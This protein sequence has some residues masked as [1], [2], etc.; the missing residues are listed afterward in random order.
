MEI[1]DFII[2]LKGKG[3]KV[4]LK[5]DDLA[6]TLPKQGVDSGLID[7]IKNQKQALVQYL[8]LHQEGVSMEGIPRAP[9]QDSYVLSSAQL[10]LWTLSQVPEES[11]AYNM[12]AVMPIEGEYQIDLL[13]RAIDAVIDRH[14]IL[15]TVFK[16]NG[17]G[18][19]RQQV[20]T[21]DTLGFETKT[22]DLSASDRASEQLESFV[23]ED[24]PQP[25]D[26][27][28]GPL[29]RVCLFVM[30]AKQHVI[31]FNL[32]HIIG[33]GW[34]DQILLGDVLAYYK[35]FEQETAV[36]LPALKIQYKDYAVWEQGKLQRD[37]LDQH[38]AY[39]LEHLAG[40]LPIM[41]LPSSKIR[42]PY[43][44]N[45]GRKLGTYIGQAN[46]KHL[47]QYCHTH[48]G[49]L[50]MGFM[51]VLKVLFSRYTQQSDQIIGST[52]SG[53]VHADLKNQIGFYANKIAFRSQLAE[54]DTFDTFFSKV[55]QL[56]LDAYAHQVYPFDHLI[57]NLKIKRDP[58]RSA[59]VDVVIDYA[60]FGDIPIEQSQRDLGDEVKDQGTVQSKFDLFFRFQETG[61]DIHFTVEY[62]ADVYHHDIVVQFVKHFK[63]L[64]YKI[65]EDTQQNLCDIRFL[66]DDEIHRIKHVFNATAF[67]YPD[68]STLH[69]LFSKQARFSPEAIAI[70]DHANHT[71]Q[72]VEER[73]NQ[74]G[75]L[76]INKLQIAKEARVGLLQNRSALFM[77]SLL[78]VF[79]SGG[80]YVP[81]NSAYPEE[82]LLF[83]LED[84][85]IEVLLVD[86][87]H[88]GLAKRLQSQSTQLKTLVLV[89][90]NLPTAG[91]FQYNK[92]DIDTEPIVLDHVD[93][94][95]DDLAYVIY[96]SGSTGRP[97]GVM[98]AHQGLVNTAYDHIDQLGLTTDD[99]ILQFVSLSFDGSLLDIFMTFFAGATLVLPEDTIVKDPT[100]FEAFIDAEKVTLV[101]L[102]PAYL[103]ALNQPKL[104][105]VHTIIT[106]GE[107]ASVKDA[108]HYA[109]EKRFFN[110]YGP[111]ECTVNSTL[112]EVDPNK[113]YTN[114]P[115]GKPSANKKILI[116]DKN[117]NLEPIGVV[118]EICISG[119]GIAK[120]YQNNPV[121]TKAK[122]VQAPDSMDGVLYKTGDL[123]RWLPHGVIEY[124][125]R[126]DDQVK[127]RGYRIEPGEIESALV[128]HKWVDMAAVSIKPD[129]EGEP[130]L[131]AYIQCWQGQDLSLEEIRSYLSRLL[132]AFML[133]GQYIYV[134]TFPL[135]TNGKVDR[136]RLEEVEGHQVVSGTAA[137]PPAN[138]TEEKLLGIWEKLLGRDKVSTQ[139]NFFDLGGHSIKATKLTFQL[140]STF[141]VNI[142]LR[143]VFTH[144]TIR[145]QAQLVAAKDKDVDVLIPK[146]GPAV[147]YP[148]SH[149]QK[150]LWVL[151]QFEG[152]NVAY[153][154]PAVI[155]LDKEMDI[156]AFKKAVEAT[157]DRH[158]ILR[159]AFRE[160]EAGELR[161]YVIPMKEFD[162]QIDTI[163]VAAKTEEDIF[164]LIDQD[165]TAPFDLVNG[166]LIRVK[167]GFDQK[168]KHIFYYNIHHIIS[169]GWS[170]EVLKKDVLTFYEAFIKGFSPELP[171]LRIQYKDYTAWQ[172]SQ[173]DTGGFQRHRDY[174]LDKL[175]GDLAVLDLPRTKN[176]PSVKTYNGNELSTYL[177]VQVV[178]RAKQYLGQK[179]GTM[180]MLLV[181]SLKALLHRYTHQEDIII[182]S[183]IAGREHPD[184]EHQI[185]FYVNTLALRDEIKAS[186]SFDELFAKV[187][188]TVA[189]AFRHQQ[190]PF[191]LLVDELDLRRDAS[192]SPIFDIMLVL[193]NNIATGSDEVGEHSPADI[194]EH[195]EKTSKFDLLFNFV[196]QQN[197]IALHVEY[198]SDVYDRSMVRRLMDHYQSLLSAL[199]KAPEQA[200]GK[201]VYLSGNETQQLLHRFNDTREDYESLT[202][203]QLFER[204][205]LK[206]PQALAVQFEETSL[207]YSQVNVYSNRLANYLRIQCQA[208][209]SVNIG[210]MLERSLESV[211]AMFAVIKSGACYVPV[212]YNYPSQRVSYILK[213]AGIQTIITQPELFG[214]HDL[215]GMEVI[216]MQNIDLE[217][218]DKNNPGNINTLDDGAFVI[219]TSGSTGN[220][221]GVEQT[222]RM[223]SNLIQW[224]IHH[225]GVA[226]GLKHLQYAS[227]S[228][229]ASLHDIYFALSS[230]GTVYV[231]SEGGR[232]DYKALREVIMEQQLEVLS[233]PFSALSNFFSLNGIDEFKGHTIQHIVSTAEQLYVGGNLGLF[234]KAYPEV[235]LHNH[236]GP[237]E[238]HVVTSHQMSENDGNIVNRPP[239][240]KPI[241]NTD[242][243]I[244]DPHLNP[245]PIGVRGEVYIGGENLANGYLNLPEQTDSKFILHPF[246]PTGKVYKTG[247]IAYWCENGTIEY[248]GRWDD[249][250][251]IRGYR[252]ELGEIEHTLLQYQEVEE[253]VVLHKN[254]ELVVYVVANTEIDKVTLKTFL[255]SALPYYMVP[256]YYIQLEAVPLTPNG[257]V[258]KKLLPQPDAAALAHRVQYVAPKDE[259]EE[260]IVSIWESVL[261]KEKIG[262]NDDFF[263]LGGHSLKATKLVN[264]YHKTFDVKLNLK[265][266]FTH[267]TL[268]SHKE[269]LEVHHWI[270]EDEKVDKDVDMETFNF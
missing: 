1:R 154:M 217:A 7:E 65:L 139:D 189:G 188:A 192:R 76:L 227:F 251:K 96:T 163:D 138:A 38:K 78:A 193:Q 29:I 94:T 128:S 49:S 210:V 97:K 62:N 10:R 229:D 25:F 249:Q 265:D 32:H 175:G 56:T 135:T 247:D 98:V 151:S 238:T 241:S 103:K 223:M 248:I 250:V 59:L 168:G 208:D 136:K 226:T 159:T 252:I 51:A 92:N 118:G 44:T 257:K 28:N 6:L 105:T 75:N 110:A 262:V 50:F 80:V 140:N 130:Q 203:S 53:R 146:V 174:W 222:H 266:L 269:L 245:V 117:L 161:Q 143:D 219:Y 196:E 64:L 24:E 31:Y 120:G 42:P 155:D 46:K 187:K 201:P 240:G 261:Q 113:A 260:K 133:P 119:T 177:P 182:G 199:T 152:A 186:D 115:I 263:D 16:V 70:K 112:Y 63:S 218:L 184:V 41:D 178:S 91:A 191:D 173:F 20:L 19:V 165:A 74:L 61:D 131:I 142:S 104:P 231:A 180:F 204:Q 68:G 202:V 114:I 150:R 18:E 195:G 134:D 57:D 167:L 73:S 209:P 4:G 166:P 129:H 179:G 181:A 14:E 43:K 45:N 23:A 264:E 122:F 157:V 141:Q 86:E 40:S 224:D 5:G 185:G 55:K 12:P 82:R 71:Y 66:D 225:S 237:S 253:A 232:L 101:T 79:K 58:R 258:D 211:I 205:A 39:W 89:D 26:L 109:K 107:A 15:R 124:L 197:T 106:A 149:A 255:K 172:L 254:D 234:L 243:Y 37:E 69:Q 233:F 145:S 162:F 228:F 85:K 170:M 144:P 52:V 116:L 200:I 126:K 121:L 99:R 81:L 9:V 212:D 236:Y 2:K 153:N 270:E 221:K 230:G 95:A 214:F 13:L 207:T 125:G 132:P 206:T 259:L 183:P 246:D 102:P 88:Q 67:A 36:L 216:D 256:A 108:V 244:L 83:M 148:I 35:A 268:I 220:P 267:S 213:D 30:P 215:S 34:S 169:D 54:E 235:V 123:G 198:N 17:K 176:R 127:L 90:S 147:D 33:D 242:L 60:D 111:T 194:K 87:E 22:I 3:I 171:S 156:E 137:V 160:N 27:V 93:V 47:K 48:G 11:A 239:I 164:T 100:L 190:Y 77:E 72:A 21:R 158:E 84:S 8:K